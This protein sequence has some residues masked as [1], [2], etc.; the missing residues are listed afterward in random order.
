MTYIDELRTVIQHLHGVESKHVE[1]ISI[2]ETHQGKTVWKGVVEVFD[3][4][5]HP[6]ATKSY[7]GHTAQTIPSIHAATLRFC[8]RIQSNRLGMLSAPQ[9]NRRLEA[10]SQQKKSRGPGRPRLPKGHAKGQIVPVRLN[11]KT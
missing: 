1:S 4:I 11:L 7:L 10:L 2:K 8:I 3:L 9:S 5:G 6:A